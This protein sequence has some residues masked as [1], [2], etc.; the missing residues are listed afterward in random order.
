[1]SLT[2]KLA[3]L[4]YRAARTTAAVIK[5]LIAFII[6]VPP[7][8]GL[9][10]S[11][12]R[13]CACGCSV[14]D[15]GGS[16]LPQENDHGGRVFFE[17]W[18]G[19]QNINW[20]GN[21]KGSAVA[22]TDRQ[23]NTSW[24]NVGFEYMFNREWGVMARLPVVN[25]NF[26]TTVDQTTGALQT[27]N[28]RDIGDLEIM[29]IY[30][31]FFKDMST[32]V[33]FGLK[34]PTGPDNAFGLDRDSQIGSGSTDLILGGF[35][36]GL[37]TGDNAW[38]YFSQIRWQQPFL[39]RYALDPQSAFDG[40]PNPTV[41]QLYK[42]GYQVDGAGGILYNNL[43]NVLGLDKITPLAQIIVSHRANDT[44]D[45]ADPYNSGFDRLMISPGIEFTKVLDEVNNRV[46]K[47]YLDVEIPIYYRTNAADNGGPLGIG[48][49]ATGT[50]GQLVAPYLLKAIASYNF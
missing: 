6:A 33:I 10:T 1:M 7:L 22:N 35:H 4:R 26:T 20:I 17:Y 44:G 16:L 11:A 15:V 37:L 23:L 2:S 43:Y 18:H 36:R 48:P 25:R 28:T 34:L 14:F 31:G 50:E 29:G 13:A 5:F 41:P 38:Q 32:G 21:A 47:L 12:A 9:T 30:T 45:A 46:F 27:F 40:N 39:Y 3:R 24:Y 42:P 19:D 49:N 8:V